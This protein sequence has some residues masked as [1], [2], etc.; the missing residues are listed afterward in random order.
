[1]GSRRTPQL[2]WTTWL[3]ESNADSVLPSLNAQMK[4][5]ARVKGDRDDFGVRS[6]LTVRQE[7]GK[8]K[9]KRHGDTLWSATRDGSIH[10]WD[11]TPTPEGE[12]H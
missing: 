5:I 12:H 6:L 2:D 11:W 3:S 9:N 8:A 10:L 7:D 1:M 4:E